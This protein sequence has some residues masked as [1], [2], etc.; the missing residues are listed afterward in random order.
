MSYDLNQGD[1]PSAYP[2]LGSG[3]E[4]HKSGGYAE[5][6]QQPL[7]LGEA[8]RQLPAQYFRVFTKPSAATF[9]QEKGKAAW[10]IIW[11]QA[12]ILVIITAIFRVIKILITPTHQTTNTINTNNPLNAILAPLQALNTMDPVSSVIVFQIW[13][14]VGL[15]IGVGIYFLIAKVCGGQG[16][17]LQ[18][19]YSTLLIQIPMS[20]F[21]GLISLITIISIN[22]LI[23]LIV[24]IYQIVLQ[25][26]MTMAVHRLNGGRATLAVLIIPIVLFILTCAAVALLISHSL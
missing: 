9:A 19:M 22:T 16:T 23:F 11:V 2:P 12:L 24:G 6:S 25:V 8:M 13:A 26:Y 17:F 1:H 14:I 7:L 20:I 3:Y 18:H 21:N 4:P 15:F 10:N 5:P